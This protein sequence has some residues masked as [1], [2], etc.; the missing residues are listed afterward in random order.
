M[1]KVRV[2]QQC[3]KRGD[4]VWKDEVMIFEIIITVT[5]ADGKRDQVLELNEIGR[6]Y[7]KI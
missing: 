6:K 4:L 1:I 5:D 3:G 2:P 7:V